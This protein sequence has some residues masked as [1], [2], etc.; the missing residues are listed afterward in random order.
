MS[1]TIKG[2]DDDGHELNWTIQSKELIEGLQTWLN[3][4]MRLGSGE[5]PET[6]QQF[7]DS[8]T[9]ESLY[10]HRTWTFHISPNQ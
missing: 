9:L 6:A 8:Q 5:F 1:W 4:P 10:V 2:I 7:V 3:T